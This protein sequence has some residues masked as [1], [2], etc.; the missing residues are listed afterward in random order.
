MR[1]A[2]L[3]FAPLMLLLFLACTDTPAEPETEATP[4][5]RMG[6]TPQ[7]PGLYLHLQVTCQQGWAAIG[8]ASDNIPQVPCDAFTVAGNCGLQAVTPSKSSWYRI[9]PECAFGEIENVSF[10]SQSPDGDVYTHHQGPVAYD[11]LKD[12]DFVHSTMQNTWRL[13]LVTID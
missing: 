13:G 1:P 5:F 4:L 6:P 3:V 7:E 8:R 9:E 2:V 12:G 10:R 11:Y